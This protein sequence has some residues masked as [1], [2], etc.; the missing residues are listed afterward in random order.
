M[1]VYLNGRYVDAQDASVSVNDRGF[2]FGDGV[3]EVVR[4]AGGELIEPERHVRRMRQGLGALAIAL[5]HDQVA[6]LLDVSR[7]LLRDNGLDG[8]ALAYCQV[9]RGAAPRTH[10]YPPADTPPTVLVTTTAV[11][12]PHA[13]RVQGATVVTLPDI[14]WA[15]CD[16]KSV[17]LLPN[18]MAKQ[19]AVDA[20]ADEAI[21]VRDGV[22]TEG[23]SSSVF[24][25]LDG[26]LRTYPLSNYILPGVTREIVLELAR[27]LGLSVREV[28]VLADELMR[29][30]EIILTSTFNDVMPVVRVDG[31]VVGTGAPG[32]IAQQLYAAFAERIGAVAGVR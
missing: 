3:Y 21:F 30:T 26:E 29:A 1:R 7:M 8:D 32:P 27:E 25:V 4:G 20:A 17:N 28:P 9:T 14:R 22:I 19:R 16:I 12:L 24:A 11:A 31:R 5:S 6:A 13:V 18:V 15:R 10:H 2:L 23:A